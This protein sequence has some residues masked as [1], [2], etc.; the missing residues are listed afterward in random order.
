MKSVKR[1]ACL[2]FV[3]MLTGCS[4][5]K[6]SMSMFLAK[7][8]CSC[9]F[10]VEQSEAN[11]RSAIRMGLAVGD[12]VVNEV[13]REVTGKAEDGSSPA[14]FGFVSAKLGCELKQ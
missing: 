9:R 13:A 3:S 4:V 2:I 14:T 7:E 10:L 5:D 6:D 12:V 1:L 8:M 11:C